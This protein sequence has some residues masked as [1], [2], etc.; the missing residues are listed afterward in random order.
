MWKFASNLSLWQGLS[1]LAGNVTWYVSADSVEGV[2]EHSITVR[3]SDE[4]WAFFTSSGMWKDGVWPLD[5]ESNQGQ[6]VFAEW[7]DV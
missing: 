6:G 5:Q 4:Q 2:E 7:G 3:N 1:L